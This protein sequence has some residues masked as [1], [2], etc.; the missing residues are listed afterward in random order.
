MLLQKIVIEGIMPERALSKLQ[1]EG[2]CVYHAKKLKKNQILLSVK[3]KDSEK[4]FAIYP[5]VCYN[6]PVYSPYTAKKAGAEGLLAALEWSKKRLGVFI[7]ILLFLSCT[8]VANRFVFRIDVVGTDA[9][10]REVL[11]A[12]EESGIRTFAPYKKGC[13]G[14]VS[15][16]ILSLKDVSYCS[17]KKSGMTVRVEVRLNAFSEPTPS[18]GDMTAKHSGTLLQAAVLRGTLLKQS[19]ESVEAGEPLVGAYFLTESGEQVPVTAIARVS[20][21]CIYDE[22]VEAETEEEAFAAAY[23]AIDGEI[24]EKSCEEAVGGFRV[25]IAYT[26]TETINF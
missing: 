26:V 15:A 5:N 11:C 16:K 21:A 2:I 12:L 18:V 8:L 1:R 17:V 14:E 9:Y 7:G 13:V 10:R 22:F 6:I 23:L 3:R 25:K 20:I 19:G 4:V 24:T